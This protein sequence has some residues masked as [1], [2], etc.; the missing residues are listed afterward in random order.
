MKNS[1][2]VL[3]AVLL[4]GLMSSCLK[5]NDDGLSYDQLS[6]VTAVNAVAGSTGYDIGLD[7]NKLNNGWNEK[8]AF[9]E[10]LNYRNA[11]PGER[12]V[13]VFTPNASATTAPLVSQKLTFETGKYYSLFV[14]GKETIEVL[15][16]ED[17]ILEPVDG[18]AQIRFANL[19]FDAGLVD[20]S[21]EGQ[22]DLNA[23]AQ[24]YK[25]VTDYKRLKAA[26]QYKITIKTK[27]QEP[28]EFHLDLEVKSR[29]VITVALTGLLDSSEDNQKLKISVIKY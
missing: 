14:I 16:L 22:E 9:E 18:E 10:Y 23:T 19:G 26:Q 21:V 1:I 17:K 8:F 3:I 28:K 7:D 5:N 29:A 27:G 4:L 20:I 25:S 24:A 11:Y 6:A 2:K 12:L 15:A 13:R